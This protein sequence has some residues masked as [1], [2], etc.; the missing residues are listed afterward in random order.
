MLRSFL[1]SFWREIHFFTT[2]PIYA[3]LS[4]LIPLLCF[5]FFAT[6]MPQGLPSDLPV[7]ILDQDQSVLSR[8][9][10]RQAESTQACRITRHFVDAGQALQAMQQGKIFGYLEIPENLAKEMY[11]GNQPEIHFYYNQSYLIAGS[12]VLKDLS[13]A[14][15]T[16][17]AG[18]RLKTHL[19]RGV[20]KQQAITAVMPYR[21]EI[22]AIGNP[23]INY[24]VYLIN[25]IVP[26]LLHLMV[27][28]TTVFVIGSE[29]KE[30]RTADWFQPDRSSFA[31]A[32]AGKLFP[33]TLIFS[34]LGILMNVL[35]FGVL[36]YPLNTNPA[37]MLLSTGFM[38]LAA[39]A[40]GIL[41]IG[42]FP[43]LRIGLSFAGLYGMLAFSYSGLS[44]PVEGMPAALR[45]WSF[46]FPLRHYFIVYQKLALNGLP[47]RSAIQDYAC[48]LLFL[49]LP[50]LILNRLKSAV[51][52]QDYP[53][54]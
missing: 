30:R 23:W 38:V 40:T 49:G 8:T 43:V 31:L 29:I 11:S 41:M 6:M 22:H 25:V 26:G 42:V 50:A 51:I 48:L 45:G 2:R 24:S 32:L 18:I 54:N 20:D 53:D 52:Q 37:W 14:L 12:L 33:Y 47:V 3:I 44:F 34:M 13:T 35:L 16:V 17:S 10:I 21:A 9:I 15:T 1:L 28:I 19:A 36:Q 7:G 4:I 46:L 27:L 39:Q 5:L